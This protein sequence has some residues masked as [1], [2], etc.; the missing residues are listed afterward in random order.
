MHRRA[1]VNTTVRTQAVCDSLCGRT[2]I[3]TILFTSPYT[4]AV[5]LV[6]LH[7]LT[8]NLS[9]SPFTGSTPQGQSR[10]TPRTRHW[11]STSKMHTRATFPKPVT[12]VADFMDS[13]TPSVVFLTCPP[14][15]LCLCMLL[16]CPIIHGSLVGFPA[17]YVA[18]L[19]AV[20]GLVSL[21]GQANPLKR[22]RRYKTS[23]PAWLA[24]TNSASL[25]LNVTPPCRAACHD[26][27][28]LTNNDVFDC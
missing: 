4:L 8:R 3:Y 5:L 17:V 26:M 20:A 23:L 16:L 7:T 15:C 27:R 11:D 2:Y 25:L 9:L 10:T 22:A 21:C 24:A 1:R 28:S 18:V 14:F 19:G 6:N 12:E 13:P